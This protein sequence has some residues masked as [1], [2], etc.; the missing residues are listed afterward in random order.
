MER[1][2]PAGLCADEPGRQ[3]WASTDGGATYTQV[4][5]GHFGSDNNFQF[6]G[7]FSI[8]SKSSVMLKVQEVA[9]WAKERHP[10]RPRYLT[11]TR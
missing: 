9:N 3:V 1:Q 8:G 10:M 7:T 11:V 4:G 6:S 2:Q 5:R